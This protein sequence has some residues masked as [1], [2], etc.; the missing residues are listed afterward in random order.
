MAAHKQGKFWE[1]VD[2]LYADT[3]TQDKATLLKYAKEL[4]LDVAQFEADFKDTETLRYVRMEAEAGK[5]IGVSGTPSMYLNGAKLSA[6]VL[7]D[8]K[9]AIDA[10]LAE[11]K[12]LTDAGDSVVVARGKRVQQSAG[13]SKFV[14]FIVNREPMVVDLKPGA[15][16]GKAK[17]KPKAQP[18]DKTV[19][20]AEIFPGDPMK[21]PA[22]A[23]VTVVECTDFQ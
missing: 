5:R 18:V 2:K 13:G 7:A 21:G 15:D 9:K 6:R 16:P 1:Y 3:K 17:P 14:Q 11:V 23:L 19:Y 22:D 4:G 12:K 10:E 8:Y 20:N